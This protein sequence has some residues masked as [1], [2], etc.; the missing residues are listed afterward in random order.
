MSDPLEI[1]TREP[2]GE[3]GG[4][5]D[6][7]TTTSTESMSPLN[8]AQSAFISFKTKWHGVSCKGKITLAAVISAAASFVAFFV[9]RSGS[10]VNY[11][12]ATNSTAVGH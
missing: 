11:W 2:S 5:T 10:V 3:L 6:T 4:R 9:S 8:R 12:Q 7:T 1:N